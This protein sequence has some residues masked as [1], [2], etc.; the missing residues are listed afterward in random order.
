MAFVDA[1]RPATAP[2][3]SVGARSGVNS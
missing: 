3:Q 2:T 1:E